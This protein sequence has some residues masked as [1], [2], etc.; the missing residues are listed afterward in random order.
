MLNPALPLIRLVL[1]ISNESAD[2][3]IADVIKIFIEIGLNW[4]SEV[5]HCV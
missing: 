4:G 1:L 2:T 3:E 5:G